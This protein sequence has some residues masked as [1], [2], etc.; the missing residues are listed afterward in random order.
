V[1]VQVQEQEQ[2]QVLVLAREE[3]VQ[4]LLLGNLQRRHLARMRWQKIR[5]AKKYQLGMLPI[6]PGRSPRLRQSE[7]RCQVRHY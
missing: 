7:T 5:M 1:Q 2:E 6:R 3:L 4:A